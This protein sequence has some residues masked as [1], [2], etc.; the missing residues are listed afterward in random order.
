MVSFLFN[1][2]PLLVD[3]SHYDWYIFQTGWFNHQLVV[4]TLLQLG[5]SFRSPG[6]QDMC[7]KLKPEIGRGQKNDKIGVVGDAKKK[8]VAA[9]FC[10]ENGCHET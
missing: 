10:C 8:K 5:I 3:D 2:D 9:S 6:R 7:R 4:T 1:V